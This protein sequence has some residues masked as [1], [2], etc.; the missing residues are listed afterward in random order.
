MEF[1]A[2]GVATFSNED[3]LLLLFERH[4]QDPGSAEEGHLRLT[5]GTG[6]FAGIEGQC[7]YRMNNGARVWSVFAKC[8]W[9]YSFPYR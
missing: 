9:L 4:A 7:N 6:S 8:E 3:T 2:D 1:E 5:G